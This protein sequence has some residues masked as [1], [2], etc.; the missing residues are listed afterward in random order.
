MIIMVRMRE[1]PHTGR[2]P[3]FGGVRRAWVADPGATNMVDGPRWQPR[4]RIAEQLATTLPSVPTEK[5]GV[6]R[7]RKTNFGALHGRATGV[8]VNGVFGEGGY[9]DIGIITIPWHSPISGYTPK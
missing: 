2:I 6:T 4:R 5:E 8:L 9:F 7:G 3:F 1:Y